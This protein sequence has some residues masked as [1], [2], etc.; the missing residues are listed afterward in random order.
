MFTVKHAYGS[1]M[2]WIC[3]TVSRHRKDAEN[4]GMVGRNKYRKSILPKYIRLYFTL[5]AGHLQ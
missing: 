5:G 1:N 3:F 4:N 2:L